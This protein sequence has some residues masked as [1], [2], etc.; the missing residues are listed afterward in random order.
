MH[1]RGFPLRAPRGGCGAS[2]LRFSCG[3][4]TVFVFLR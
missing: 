4:G 3:G 1:S 2:S